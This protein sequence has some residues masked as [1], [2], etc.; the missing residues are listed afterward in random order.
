MPSIWLCKVLVNEACEKCRN[1]GFGGVR[2]VL[3]KGLGASWNLGE[4]EEGVELGGGSGDEAK[5]GDVIGRVEEGGNEAG[6]VDG[7]GG[8]LRVFGSDIGSSDRLSMKGKVMLGVCQV[9]GVDLC[10]GDWRIATQ[11]MRWEGKFGG[12]ALVCRSWY[13]EPCSGR[14]IACFWTDGSTYCA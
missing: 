5:I 7:F 9:N 1:W 11:G 3:E 2:A 10:K 14:D 4:L 12:L 13:H 6:G 8:E